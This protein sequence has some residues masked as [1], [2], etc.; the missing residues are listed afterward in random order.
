[1]VRTNH[2]LYN[3]NLP[4]S[5]SVITRATSSLP[6]FQITLWNLHGFH[7]SRN[8]PPNIICYKVSDTCNTLTGNKIMAY[9][10]YIYLKYT[11][12][13]PSFN[14][15]YQ[16]LDSFYMYILR[17]HI[18]THTHTSYRVVF[19]LR[20]SEWI[21]ALKMKEFAISSFNLSKWHEGSKKILRLSWETVGL[22]WWLTVDWGC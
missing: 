7:V 10:E 16:C 13:L 5:Y 3:Q 22:C 17:C 6:T 21:I 2:L 1:M 4:V 9:F 14:V 15:T 12:L 20:I 11:C 8:L 18:H 19:S